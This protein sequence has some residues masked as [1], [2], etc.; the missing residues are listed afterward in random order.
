VFLHI[1]IDSSTAAGV[2]DLVRSGSEIDDMLDLEKMDSI[3]RKEA[4]GWY[5]YIHIHIYI[6]IYILLIGVFTSI[7]YIY[8]H[9]Y[10][11]IY[12]YTHLHIYICIRT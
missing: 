1:G 8:I 5:I 4:K 7:T 9:I 3:E 12:T 11:Y 2:N 10:I 6:Y